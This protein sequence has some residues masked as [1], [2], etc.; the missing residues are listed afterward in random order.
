MTRMLSILA[1]VRLAAIACLLGAV[2]GLSSAKDGEW[3]TVVAPPK[4]SF[5]NLGYRLEVL[6]PPVQE[7]PNGASY[8]SRVTNNLAIATK[9]SLKLLGPTNA[10]FSRL[11]IICDAGGSAAL[12]FD[13]V[14]VKAIVGTS[15][16]PKSAMAGADKVLARLQGNAWLRKEACQLE[17]V[18]ALSPK[19]KPI[20]PKSDAQAKREAEAVAK[21]LHCGGLF[22]KKPPEAP[23]MSH[24]EGL[25]LPDLS[26]VTQSWSKVF[27]VTKPFSP[28][29]FQATRVGIATERP[30]EDKK[31]MFFYTGTFLVGKQAEVIDAV[32]KE[33]KITG[34]GRFSQ[35]E[36]SFF[37][38]EG[39]TTKNQWS[40]P[41]PASLLATFPKSKKKGDLGSVQ[42]SVEIEET[43][44]PQEVLVTCTYVMRMN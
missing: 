17:S 8:E 9:E 2:C 34:K 20:P 36:A 7:G 43:G 37:V 4:S 31:T 42:G 14:Q 23:L 10:I 29:G 16:I 35:P 44:N 41:L 26:S 30:E 32:K 22:A 38:G 13:N 1:A 6:L 5:A 3:H 40:Y 27:K 33:L 39:K 28:Y 19:P 25:Q 12:D 18:V 21:I 15:A 11:T 24:V